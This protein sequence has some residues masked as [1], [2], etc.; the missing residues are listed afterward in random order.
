MRKLLFTLVLVLLCSC[1]G[2]VKSQTSYIFQRNYSQ[3]Q[4]TKILYDI[5]S[6]FSV[7]K[8]SPIPLDQWITFKMDKDNGYIEQK[9][10]SKYGNT[11]LTV[12]YYKYVVSDSTYYQLKIRQTIT[13]K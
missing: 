3:V 11:T 6:L 5:D 10:I 1:N 2:D 12:M 9:M 8:I 4:Q 7:Y 13:K